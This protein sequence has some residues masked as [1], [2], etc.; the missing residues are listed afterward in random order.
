MLA[1]RHRGFRDA[2]I[3]RARRI[4]CMVTRHRGGYGLCGRRCRHARSTGCALTSVRAQQVNDQ[5]GCCD[6]EQS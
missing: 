5:D 6:D 2:V 4:V 1:V 3:Q